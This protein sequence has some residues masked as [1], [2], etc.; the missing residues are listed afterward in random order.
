MC[1]CV[2]I[3]HTAPARTAIGLEIVQKLDQLVP[4]GAEQASD[5]LRLARVGD[6]H[7]EHVERLVLQGRRIGA[8]Q[9]HNQLQID[10]VRNVAHHGLPVGAVQQ[11]LAKQLGGAVEGR[12]ASVA[13]GQHQGKSCR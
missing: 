6:K 3:R 2:H 4:V 5:L 13:G 10:L 8:Q 1:V 12:A 9:R 11:Q 7:L